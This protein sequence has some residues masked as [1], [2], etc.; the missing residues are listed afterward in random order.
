MEGTKRVLI[1]PL[2]TE[3]SNKVTEKENKYA[4]LVEK[5]ATKHA[6]RKAV[7]E[8]FNVNVVAVNTSITPGKVKTKMT[9]KGVVE[10]RKSA[11]KK[12]YITI[13]EGQSIDIYN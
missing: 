11:S 9:K 12:A 1:K 4:F 2:V 6:I 7:E 3:K 10:G 5:T 8:F 13:K